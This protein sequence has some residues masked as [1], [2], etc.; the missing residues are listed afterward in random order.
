V[1][2]AE[3]DQIARTMW[4]HLTSLEQQA[5]GDYLTYATVKPLIVAVIND[6]LKHQK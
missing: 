2:A 3:K 6:V 4:Q 1:T 5:L